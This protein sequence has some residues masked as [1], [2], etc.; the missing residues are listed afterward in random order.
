MQPRLQSITLPT[1]VR[2]RRAHLTTLCSLALALGTAQAQTWLQANAP[3]NTW[4]SI[5]CS[6]DGAKLV[7][8]VGEAGGFIYT[9]ADSGNSWF[10]S[11]GTSNSWSSVASSADGTRIFAAA[12]LIYTSTNSGLHW[13]PTRAPSQRWSSVACSADG[14]KVLASCGAIYLSTDSGITWTTNSMS[15]PGGIFIACSATASTLMLGGVYL[16]YI[17]TNSGATW[18]SNLFP[19]AYCW[20][21]SCSADGTKLIVVGNGPTSA[22]VYTSTNRGIAWKTNN[23]GPFN[24]WHA[25]A[26]SADGTKMIAASNHGLFTST[27]SGQTWLT[28]SVPDLSWSAVAS[29]ADGCKL[30]AAVSG[31]GI[32]ES[33]TTPEPQLA[34]STSGN[35]QLTLSWLVPSRNFS[36]QQASDLTLAD[37]A[38]LTTMPTLNFTNLQNEITL[39]LSNTAAFYRLRFP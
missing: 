35:N 32:Y 27:D 1:S 12:G 7:A 5:A 22:D 34:L 24:Q 25:A 14:K 26:S 28:N 17:S 18:S 33:Q 39:P 20:G 6:A 38:A 3:T 31:A 10:P 2:L 4:T 9:S 16:C 37:W 13:T 23:L 19:N 15:A 36:A 30:V 21:G 29:S 8:S 11:S